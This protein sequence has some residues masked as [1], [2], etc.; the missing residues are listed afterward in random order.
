MA[1]SHERAQ[2]G[3]DLS[4]VSPIS[5]DVSSGDESVVVPDAVTNE[6]SARRRADDLAA[7]AAYY[8]QRAIQEEQ[9]LGP[10]H[11]VDLLWSIATSQAA[12][13]QRIRTG[14]GAS[15]RPSP[16]ATYIPRT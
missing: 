7:E 11:Y 8:R 14:K 13:A 1:S 3:A 15:S 12:M 5:V 6:D 16:P 4:G 9:A 2:R 10:G